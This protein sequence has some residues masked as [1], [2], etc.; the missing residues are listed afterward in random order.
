MISILY[1]EVYILCILVLMLIF[2][3]LKMGMALQIRK[4]L[5]R[6][7]L[8]SNCCLFVFDAFWVI[9]NSGALKVSVG[10]NWTFNAF[11]YITVALVSYCWFLYSENVQ[12]SK[13]VTSV[14][15][16]LL[17][18]IP[19]FLIIILVILSV[20]FKWLFY[21]DNNNVYHR[22]K[23]Y[24]VQ[25]CCS[26]GYI[27]FTASKAWIA[28]FRTK[29][30]SRKIEYRTVGKFVIAP[31][32]F[33][34]LQVFYPHI[35]LLCIGTTFGCLY[36]FIKMQE[37]MIST[38]ALTGLNNKDELMRRLSEN[39]D[40]ADNKK[41][42]YLVMM[43]L[44]AFKSINDNFGHLEGDNALKIVASTLNICCKNK[45]YFISRFGGDEFVAI[46]ELGE[47]ESIDDFKS[48]VD[49]VLREKCKECPF[50]ISISMGWKE[51]DPSIKSEQEFI[52]AADSE[53][54]K[55]KYNKKAL[56]RK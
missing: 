30:Y 32:I 54:Y 28:S 42:M 29:I 13:L 12:G 51:Y 40:R 37:F 41:K 17:C 47:N 2:F 48:S 53:L 31:V 21:I 16:R 10:V 15:K 38:D 1:A 33:G 5:F 49:E 22:G 11:Y 36:V 23:Y 39:I 27:I 50:E 56:S 3:K 25:L 46:C 19:I 55:E 52:R 35:P 18:A 4:L 8:I 26:W 6:F 20:K 24:A 7:V 44:D 43:D 14:K 9:I 34:G 45:N